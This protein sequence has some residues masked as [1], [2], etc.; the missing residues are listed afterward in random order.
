[1]SDDWV[2]K[3]FMLMTITMGFGLAAM[4]FTVVFAFW[5]GDCGDLR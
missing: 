5:F 2:I 4:M 3:L 1:M